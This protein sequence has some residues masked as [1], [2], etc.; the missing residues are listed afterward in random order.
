MHYFSDQLGIINPLN[1]KERSMKLHFSAPALFLAGLLAF[2]SAWAGATDNISVSDAYVRAVPP[3]QPNTAAFM[4]LQNKGADSHALVA[5]KTTQANVVE[6]HTHVM[7]DNMM[8]MRPIEKI[9]VA[10]GA[11]VSLEP[12]GLHIMLIDLNA[13][14]GEEVALTLVFDDDSE[15][16]L[17][18][19]VRKPG[20][21]TMMQHHH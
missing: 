16:E 21:E 9:E 4:Q 1:I 17:T 20:E 2:P 13:P 12:G 5:A 19:P 8:K 11:S 14:L 18:L 15:I 7:E 10:G 6:L 3:G